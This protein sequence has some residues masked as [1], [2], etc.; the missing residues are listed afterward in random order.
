MR[1]LR[2]GILIVAFL[3][4]VL[5]WRAQGRVYRIVG[6]THG[7]LNVSGLLWEAAYRTTMIVNGRENDVVV[8]SVRFSQP[9]VAQLKGQFERQGAKVKLK[10]TEN[11]GAVGVAKWD[12]G[13]ARFVVMTPGNRLNRLVFLFYPVKKKVSSSKFPIPTY[14]RGKT[15]HTVVDKDTHTSCET[16]LTE[17]SIMQV[18]SYYTKAL[19]GDGWVPLLP[20]SRPGGLVWFHKQEKT[21][22]VMASRRDNGETMV[23]LLVKDAGF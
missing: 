13:K 15:T 8:Y 21:C 16:L 18:Q 1:N 6:D 11:G 12:G 20:R 23:T 9:A 5:P 4:A 17:D 10:W 22:C 19:A 7:R 2:K 3:A 14:P